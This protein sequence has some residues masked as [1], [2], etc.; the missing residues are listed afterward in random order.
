MTGQRLL[1]GD[2]RHNQRRIRVNRR[3]SHIRKC[4]EA[5]QRQ[6]RAGGKLARNAVLC[7]VGVLE[8]VLLSVLRPMDFFPWRG[9]DLRS[10]RMVDRSSGDIHPERKEE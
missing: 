8:S 9:D 6:V 5:V 2:P 3:G 7:L 4:L 10:E 1:V